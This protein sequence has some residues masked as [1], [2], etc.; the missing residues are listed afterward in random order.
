[1]KIDKPSEAMDHFQKALEIQQ[2]LSVDRQILSFALR[3]TGECFMKMNK[4]YKAMDQPAAAW[5]SG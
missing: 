4:P 5:L 2:Q 3:N 1:M